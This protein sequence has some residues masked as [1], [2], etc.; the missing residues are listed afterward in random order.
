MFRARTLLI[1]FT[2]LLGTWSAQPARAEIIDRVAARVNEEIIT[3]YEL[4]EAAVPFLLSQGLPPQ[5]IQRT[6]NDTTQRTQ[7]FTKVLDDLIERKLMGQEAAKFDLNV[8]DT[9]LEQWLEQVR[10]G[11]PE[12]EFRA[13]IKQYDIDYDDYREFVRANLLRNKIIQI[14]VRSKVSVTDDEVV[15]ECKKRFGDFDSK[16]RYLKISHV[17]VQPRSNAPA[18][19]DAA[20]QSA[21]EARERVLRGEDFIEV[22]RAMSTGPS[23]KDGGLLG[24]FTRG[25]LDPEFER[26]AFALSNGETSNVVRTRFGYHVIHIDD[27]ELRDANNTADRMDQCRGVL[28]QQGLE[29]QLESYTQTLRNRAF[30]DIKI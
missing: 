9:E 13:M 2:V 10:R 4:R 18:D 25:E 27:E 29:D 8:P 15:T 6:L 30:I 1:L 20:R 7:L 5:E 12:S 14:K 23:A 26:A 11:A 21:E 28:V 16:Q 17:L 19:V 3:L 22:A 24:T